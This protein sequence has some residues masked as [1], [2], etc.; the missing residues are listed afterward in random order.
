MVRQEKIN[1]V[2][3]ILDEY[4]KRGKTV[5]YPILREQFIQRLGLVSRY[6]FDNWVLY[7]IAKGYIKSV[8]S[9]VRQTGN[10]VVYEIFVDV[11]RRDCPDVGHGGCSF[12]GNDFA[13]VPRVR[14]LGG[15]N[16]LSSSFTKA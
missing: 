15:K 9:S 16:F 5:S 6:A 13:E 8:G 2:L 10:K 12:S 4:S 14:M 7:C 1:E 11:V 3:R